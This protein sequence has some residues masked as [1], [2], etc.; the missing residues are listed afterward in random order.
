[1]TVKKPKIAIVGSG[2]VGKAT[3]KAFLAKG[4]TVGF[5][6]R[7][8]E[9]IEKLRNEGFTAHG[10]NDFTKGDYDYDMTMLTVPTPN[11][12][13]KINLDSLE[14]AV[15][16]LGKKL[17]HTKNY[18][19][20]VVKSTCVPGTTENLVVKTI[21]EH[22]GKKV[23]KDFGACMNPEYLR[24]NSAYED[25]IDPWI[26]VIGEY[27][28]KSGDI[29][30]QVYEDFDCPIY[31][32]TLAEAEMQKYVHNLYNATKITF[33]NE[34]RHIAKEIGVDA[35]KI[36]KYTAFSC[37]GMWNPKYGIKDK[38]PFSGA[39]LP[40]DVKSFL[41]WAKRNGFNTHLLESVFIVNENMKHP[42]I[43]P[44]ANSHTNGEK[45]HGKTAEQL[46][47]AEQNSE[48]QL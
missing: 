26:T 29:L 17:R 31:R 25:S 36:F 33:Y 40:K 9:Q 46:R 43:L 48:Y 20:V 12:N 16:D 27:D 8:P 34:M 19:V 21:E 39:C 4:F 45:K 2:I 10:R 15:I 28:K 38:G 32:C 18:H 44:K 1:M 23:G 42:A 14:L 5:I 37:E 13:G 11:Q 47:E 7:S 3:G 6:G 22:S 35:Q 41:H 30:M 24:E